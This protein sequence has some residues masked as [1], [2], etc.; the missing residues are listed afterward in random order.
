MDDIVISKADVLIFLGANHACSRVTNLVFAMP[1]EATAEDI[2][3][4]VTAKDRA[5]VLCSVLGAVERPRGACLAEWCVCPNGKFAER[6]APEW[7]WPRV[8]ALLLGEE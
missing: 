2:W 5:W 1:D 4:A 8:R 7:P 6:I 3:N